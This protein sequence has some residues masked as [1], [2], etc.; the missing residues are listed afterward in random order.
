MRRTSQ[1]GRDWT[2]SVHLSGTPNDLTCLIQLF[3]RFLS[4][5]SCIDWALRC[6]YMESVPDLVRLEV[7]VWPFFCPNE[8]RN[9]EMKPNAV[10]S[11]FVHTCIDYMYLRLVA[12]ATQTSTL[13]SRYKPHDLFAQPSRTEVDPLTGSFERKVRGPKTVLTPTRIPGRV[14]PGF[15]QAS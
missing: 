12:R 2:P 7:Q 5:P 11:K 9:D 15:R 13:T 1:P 10:R 8:P 3:V 6:W 14:I 4:I